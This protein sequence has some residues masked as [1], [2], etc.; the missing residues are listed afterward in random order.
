MGLVSS[1]RITDED[2]KVLRSRINIGTWLARDLVRANI[3][4]L[5]HDQPMLTQAAIA[6]RVG[7]STAKVRRT[8][9][10]YTAEGLEV[11]LHDQARPGQPRVL[12][13]RHEAFIV[14]TACTDSPAG[15][16]HWTVSLLRQKLKDE[17]SQDAGDETIRRVLLRNNLKPWLKKK[18]GASRNWTSNT[19]PGCLTYWSCMNSHTTKRILLSALT[20]RATSS[21]VRRGGAGRCGRLLPK[22]A[23]PVTSSMKTTNT[24]VMER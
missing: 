23:P 11:A 1:F 7:C 6:S 18:C 22:V 12:S 2:A 8:W 5:S 19:S 17:H 16:D 4:L 24:N 3:L 20:R 13:P 21:S 9:Q 10:R 14:A 15:T